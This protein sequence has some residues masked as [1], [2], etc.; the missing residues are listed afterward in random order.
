MNKL[1]MHAKYFMLIWRKHPIY[2]IVYTLL[3]LYT[4]AFVAFKNVYVFTILIRM[5]TERKPLTAILLFLSVALIV[6]I[7]MHSLSSLFYEKFEPRIK[8]LIEADLDLKV[9]QKLEKLDVRFYDDKDFY[10]EYTMSVVGINGRVFQNFNLIV[11]FIKSIFGILTVIPILFWANSLIISACVVLIVVLTYLLNDKATKLGYR[12]E[13]EHTPLNR[14][15]HY[16]NSIFRS[17]EYVK[18]IR[19]NRAAPMLFKHYDKVVGE[20]AAIEKKYGVKRVFMSV[21]DNV[22][23]KIIP[24]DFLYSIYLLVQIVQKRILVGDFI[25]AKN[26][27]GI[28]RDSTTQIITS[29]TQMNKLSRYLERF[30][31]FMNQENVLQI[32][33][34]HV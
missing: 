11:N 15:I 16:I 17:K 30:E 26:A 20:K 22:L 21:A 9:M 12:E 23:L 27:L 13:Q 10:N 28:V 2:I 3:E 4:T 25:G 24:Y 19:L 5:I 1:K 7:L 34:A 18:E 33:R 31:L 29:I 14:K 8:L 6:I 32:G